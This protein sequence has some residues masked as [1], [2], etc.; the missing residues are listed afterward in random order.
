MPIPL[1][2]LG[3]QHNASGHTECAVQVRRCS[4]GLVAGQLTWQ[5]AQEEVEFMLLE[6]K[7]GNVVVG[8]VCQGPPLFSKMPWRLVAS[9]GSA[10]RCCDLRKGDT[11]F[12]TSPSWASGRRSVELCRQPPAPR[13]PPEPTMQEDFCRA[14]PV[15]PKLDFTQLESSRSKSFGMGRLKCLEF[16]R[17]M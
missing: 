11:L 5:D 14:A 1:G 3:A 7:P 2:T 10:E 4:C 17:C 16:W 12:F 9:S 15:V 13:V 8:E 6:L